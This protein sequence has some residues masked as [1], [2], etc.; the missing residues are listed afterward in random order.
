MPKQRLYSNRCSE[1][2]LP[3]VKPWG[4]YFQHARQ[5]PIYLN[6]K[7]LKSQKK[8]KN[9]KV[10]GIILQIAYLGLHIKDSAST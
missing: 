2:C 8:T 6:G 4:S 9:K 10:L 7:I 5:S 3:L 1:P